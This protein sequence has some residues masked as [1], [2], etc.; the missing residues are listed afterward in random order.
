MHP[1][2][3]RPAF[4]AHA[5]RTAARPSEDLGI[6]PRW[7]LDD[8]YPGRDSAELKAAFDHV[9][10]GSVDF[11]ERWKGKLEEA[12]K[13]H[14]LGT[15]IAE[16]EALQE[17]MGRIM[18]Y[19]GLS[20]FSDTTDPANAK[21][22]G[23]TQSR[24]TDSSAHLLFFELELNRIDDAIIDR[25]M[26]TDEK[27]GHY[28]PWIV[29]LRKDK[30]YQLEDRVEQLFHEKAMTGA[31]AWNRLFDETM[32]A[33]T[34]DVDGEE[35][36]LEPTLNKL[37]DPDEQVRHR[38]ADALAA[39]FREN[40]RTFTLITN[41]L[42]KDKEIEDRWRR[43]PRPISSRNLANF[44]EDEVVDALIAAVRGSYPS[45]SHRYYK[46]KA[47]WFGVEE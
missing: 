32:A 20:Y 17:V 25:A 26:E 24:M 5:G 9:Q 14:R 6:L 34:F 39:T 22:F 37:Q 47:R 35:L 38:A 28:R 12:A 2:P 4:A 46:L 16:Y 11:E 40:L 10:K 27:A 30:P 33:L 41:T 29:D 1:S 19:A 44:V 43:F 36:S 3:R 31:G 45:L 13:D 21:F 8:L 15:A 42:A 7:N 18:S 23:D